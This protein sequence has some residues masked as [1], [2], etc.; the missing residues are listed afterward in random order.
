MN[1]LSINDIEQYVEKNIQSFHTKRLEGLKI[2]NIKKLLKRKN[3]YLFKVKNIDNANDVVK[4][5]LDAHISSSEETKFGD[6]LE[7][8]AIYICGK[9]YGGQ[10]SSSEGIDLDFTKDG[11]RYLVNIK[12]GPNWGNASQINKMVDSFTSAKKTLSTSGAKISVE[13]INGCCYGKSS[14]KLQKGYY[15]KY[16]GQKFWDFVSGDSELYTKL[17][18]PL[19][20]KAK[21]RNDEFMEKYN[22]LLNKLTLQF[23]N[24]FCDEE[25]KIDWNRIVKLN[26]SFEKNISKERVKSL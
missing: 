15:Y 20:K 13:F 1:Q 12:S 17:I 23:I 5:I 16:S 18:E 7:G 25:G 2:G 8:L 24:E 14:D 26:S 19:G 9:V 22:A 4:G 6:W 11:I 21:E 3:P 10:K